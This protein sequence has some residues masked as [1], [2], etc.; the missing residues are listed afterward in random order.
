MGFEDA[1][2][3]VTMETWETDDFAAV[4]KK[5]VF[6]GLD[7]DGDLLNVTLTAEFLSAEGRLFPE[8]VYT[9]EILVAF[10][11]EDPEGPTMTHIVQF[12]TFDYD[13]EFLQD[14]PNDGGIAW[15]L[16]GMDYHPGS[17][18][19]LAVGTNGANDLAVRGVPIGVDGQATGSFQTAF[20]LDLGPGELVGMDRYGDDLF[21]S[22][23]TGS[24]WDGEFWTEEPNPGVISYLLDALSPSNPVTS[25]FIN[26]TS[27]PLI[28]QNGV[29]ST[30]LLGGPT[31]GALQGGTTFVLGFEET[32]ELFKNPSY[33]SFSE[34]EGMS[35]GTFGTYCCTESLLDKGLTVAA[36]PSGDGDFVYA[37][38]GDRL[39]KR[40]TDG[41]LIGWV[42]LP[43]PVAYARDLE[44]DSQGRVYVALQGNTW[45]QSGLVV[46]D[47]DSLTILAERRGLPMGR[48]AVYEVDGN[49]SW[50]YYGQYGSSAIIGAV[51]VTF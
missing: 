42:I 47:V 43:S 19:V 17:S 33:L 18:M 29:W 45:D 15:G 35:V 23:P 40:D 7:E 13:S 2:I 25:W 30:V 4:E 3:T 27:Q 26:F 12:Y 50:V 51:E 32:N 39:E 28:D 6:Y 24:L 44:V 41:N 9:L 16:S 22:H 48:I 8:V 1:E 38:F 14:D 11:P 36:D 20:D 31:D 37:L 34:T 21:L 5:E 49:T 10:F 46:Y